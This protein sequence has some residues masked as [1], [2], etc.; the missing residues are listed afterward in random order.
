M[1]DSERDYCA[2]RKSGDGSLPPAECGSRGPAA[3]TAS[4]RKPDVGS[5]AVAAAL[6]FSGSRAANSHT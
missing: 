6:L 4:P 1:I 5:A 3:G 2:D